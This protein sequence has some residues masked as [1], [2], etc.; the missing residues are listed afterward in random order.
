M[1]ETVVDATIAAGAVQG[2]LAVPESRDGGNRRRRGRRGRGADRADRPQG[3]ETEDR[4][5]ASEEA[6]PNVADVVALV[7]EAGSPPA[8][9]APP[10]REPRTPKPPREPR[11][12]REARASAQ[13]SSATA[14]EA[15]PVAGLEQAESSLSTANHAPAQASTEREADMPPLEIPRAM[16]VSTLGEMPPAK[17][18]PE[19]PP[20]AVSRAVPIAPAIELPPVQLT[21][22][23]D[24]GLELV[25]TRHAAPAQPVAE[26][27]APRPKRVRPP[28]IEI[29]SEPLEI[30]ET[31]KDGAPP[32]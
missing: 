30:I 14:S 1:A 18:T 2:E 9:Q 24:S 22:P 5:F 7:A 27:G 26:T 29:T 13:A 19:V 32:A 8:T 6:G 31:R 4:D 23:A 12:A 11:V 21:L 15:L 17:A 25:E 10:P 20:P 16:P 3:D 28:K